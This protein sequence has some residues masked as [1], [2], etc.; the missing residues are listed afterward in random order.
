MVPEQGQPDQRMSWGGVISWLLHGF[1]DTQN[2]TEANPTNNVRGVCGEMSENTAESQG[3]YLPL[4]G[5]G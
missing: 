2:A 5:M 4:L 1:G 3:G